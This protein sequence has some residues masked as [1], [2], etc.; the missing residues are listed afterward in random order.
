MSTW[1]TSKLFVGVDLHKETTTLVVVDASRKKH[2]GNQTK[3][4]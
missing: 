2:L 3:E 1:R 4:I